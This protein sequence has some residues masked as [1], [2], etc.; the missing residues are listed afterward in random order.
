MR[1][2][3]S[4]T[5]GL[6]ETTLN[7]GGHLFIIGNECFNNAPASGLKPLADNMKALRAKAI[8]PEGLYWNEAWL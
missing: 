8:K 6:E 7:E 5:V 3:F 2:G 4:P 1:Q